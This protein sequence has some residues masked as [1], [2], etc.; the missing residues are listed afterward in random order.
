MAVAGQNTRRPPTRPQN[1]CES[2]QTYFSYSL[3]K[4]FHSAEFQTKLFFTRNWVGGFYWDSL[5]I[6]IVNPSEKIHETEVLLKNRAHYKPQE[7]P[8]VKTIYEKVNEI[9]NRFILLRQKQRWYDIKLASTNS[10]SRHLEH[11]FLH[12]YENPPRFKH[13]GRKDLLT[14][15]PRARMGSESI[16]HDAEGRMGYWLREAMRARGIIVLVKSNWLVKNIVAKQL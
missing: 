9:I 7:A 8:M 5:L 3:D 2:K 10:S 4:A 15:T 16:A 6:V 14:I 12:A 1:Y 13:A 11:L